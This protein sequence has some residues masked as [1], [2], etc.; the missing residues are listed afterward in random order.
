MSPSLQPPSCGPSV[1]CRLGARHIDW[2]D[3]RA[4]LADAV[5]AVKGKQTNQPIAQ[6]T[7]LHGADVGAAARLP[8]PLSPISR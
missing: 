5:E 1:R 7:Q 6:R 8:T 3:R 2:K 4:A